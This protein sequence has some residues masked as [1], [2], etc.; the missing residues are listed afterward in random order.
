MG[1]SKDY[2]IEKTECCNEK[3]IR[4]VHIFENDYL[5]RPEIVKSLI[6]SKLGIYKR[7]IKSNECVLKEIDN[8]TANVF[9]I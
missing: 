6:L 4:L 9:L 1:T 8:E 5:N 2:H 7:T 3:G